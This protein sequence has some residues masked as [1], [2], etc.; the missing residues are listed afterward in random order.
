MLL[1]EQKTIKIKPARAA[2]DD[3]QHTCEQVNT[4]K[5][6]GAF[7]QILHIFARIGQA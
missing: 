5:S 3:P 7:P 1:I 4:R 2:P 6:S